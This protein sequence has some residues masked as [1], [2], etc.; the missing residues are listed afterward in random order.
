MDKKRAEIL[1]GKGFE[2]SGGFRWS[3]FV[4]YNSKIIKLIPN[5]HSWFPPKTCSNT[6]KVIQ[7]REK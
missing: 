1:M 6:R 5:P 4:L 7:K 3:L 2:S